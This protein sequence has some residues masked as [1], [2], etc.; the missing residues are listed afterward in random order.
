MAEHVKTNFEI[1]DIKESI[2]EDCG[3]TIR[4]QN[5]DQTNN[6]NQVQVKSRKEASIERFIKRQADWL[7]QRNMKVLQRKIET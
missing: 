2:N 5:S 7:D 3:L 6:G 4:V 1:Y